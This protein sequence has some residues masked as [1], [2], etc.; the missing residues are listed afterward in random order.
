MPTA[1]PAAGSGR[2]ISERPNIAAPPGRHK[3]IMGRLKNIL[4]QTAGL[5][6]LFGFFAGLIIVVFAPVEMSKMA[7]ARPDG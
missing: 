7:E 2:W 6:Q 1:S 3:I 4:G 5:A